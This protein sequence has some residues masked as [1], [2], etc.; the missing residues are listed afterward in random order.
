[1][2][3]LSTVFRFATLGA[4]VSTLLLLLIGT[5]SQFVP[6]VGE[7]GF[8]RTFGLIFETPQAI[9]W[10]YYETLGEAGFNY[11]WFA[12]NGPFILLG[13]LILL[14]VAAVRE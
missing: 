12:W 11:D 9:I 8:G 7:V 14:T 6:M 4:A 5:I 1:M 10:A 13:S 2:K 3:Y